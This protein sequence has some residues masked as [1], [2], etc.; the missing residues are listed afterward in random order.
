MPVFERPLNDVSVPDASSGVA[1]VHVSGEVV[2]PGLVGVP[3]GGR[4]A[5]AIRAAGGALPSAD[6]AGLNLAAS[7]RD[8]EQLVVPS[9]DAPAQA[10]S[11]ET[12][13]G[14]ISLNRATPEELMAL[15][16]VGPVLAERIVA[17]RESIGGFSAVEDLLDVSGIGERTLAELRPLIQVP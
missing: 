1:T 17:H 10:G 6:L 12:H 4:V 13:G 8:G 7:V 2:R 11:D 5:D 9:V 14:P 15:P 16:G 3:S